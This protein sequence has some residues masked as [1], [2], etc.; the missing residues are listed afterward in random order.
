VSIASQL[1]T[2]EKVFQLDPFQTKLTNA[3][4]DVPH[5]SVRSLCVTC[6]I[7]RVAWHCNATCQCHY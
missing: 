3:G 1:L 6:G 7:V 2:F 4:N 5:V